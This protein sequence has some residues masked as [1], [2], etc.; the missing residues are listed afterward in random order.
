MYSIT[1]PTS[2][3]N[4]ERWMTQIETNAPEDVSKVLVGTKQDL[5]EDR[6]VLMEQGR[7]LAAKFG[8]PFLE[9]SAKTGFQ[10]KDAF[11]M[12]GKEIVKKQEEKGEVVGF[13]SQGKNVLR[14]SPAEAEKKCAC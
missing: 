8:I 3:T 12:L 13:T 14:H 7:Q 4:I 11:E 10:V 1:D 6:N 9:V 5:E 2:F